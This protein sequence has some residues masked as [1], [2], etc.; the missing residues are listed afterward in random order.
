MDAGD[1]CWWM[2]TR[3]KSDLLPALRERERE[4]EREMDLITWINVGV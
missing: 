1:G 2:F 3:Q 4:R